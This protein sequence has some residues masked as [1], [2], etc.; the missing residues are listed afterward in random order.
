M[1]SPFDTTKRAI[2]RSLNSDKKRSSILVILLA[3]NLISIA[4]LVAPLF[5]SQP[6]YPPQLVYNAGLVRAPI[7]PPLSQDRSEAPAPVAA[8]VEPTEIPTPVEVAKPS[9]SGTAEQM[10]EVMPREVLLSQARQL[11]KN[12]S[13]DMA[14][15]INQEVGKADGRL[16]VGH[17]AYEMG[18]CFEFINDLDLA[19]SHYQL[20]SKSNDRDLRL[21]AQFGQ[22]RLLRNR[23]NISETK[24]LLA[25]LML[26]TQNKWGDKSG[27]GPELQYHWAELLALAEANPEGR[28]L[29]SRKYPAHPRLTL[30][31][32]VLLDLAAGAEEAAEANTSRGPDLIKAIGLQQGHPDLASVN[33]RFAQINVVDLIKKTSEAMGYQL[34]IPPILRADLKSRAVEVDVE[35][36]SVSNLLRLALQ[37]DAATWT[38]DSV[39]HQLRLQALNFGEDSD[40]SGNSQTGGA[41]TALRGALATTPNHAHAPNAFTILANLLFEAGKKEDAIAKYKDVLVRYRRHPAR[42]FASFNLAKCYL[43]LDQREE[44]R[45]HLHSV[46]DQR[47][48]RPIESA[49]YM[50]LGDLSLCADDSKSA[51]REFSRAVTYATD[52]RSEAVAAMSLAHAYV[53]SGNPRMALTALMNSRED[54]RQEPFENPTALLA[55]YAN[56]RAATKKSAVQRFGRAM[57]SAIAFVAPEDYF[58]ATGYMLMSDV[59]TELGMAGRVAET[60]KAAVEAH[61]PQPLRDQFMFELGQ[62][63]LVQRESTDFMNTMKELQQKGV[64]EWSHQAQLELANYLL[65]QGDADECMRI[66]RAV[67]KKSKT[68]QEKAAGLRMLGRAYEKQK[69][70]Y[71]AAI[72]FAGLL[73]AADKSKADET[74]DAASDEQ[75]SASLIQLNVAGG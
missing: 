69:D 71:N 21:A 48:G 43:T 65:R 70:H 40:V 66:C 24:H 15:Q 46:V 60:R 44:A 59:Y 1:R 73:P 41:E 4:I 17:L 39:T 28:D 72:C 38:Y 30:T 14:I 13:F 7:A 32:Q 58:G 64:N 55:A 47:S 26:Q 52:A 22:S 75:S 42:Q 68:Q 51:S 50:F 37:P 74:D 20:A 10:A 54:L 31:P 6:T 19:Q 62:Y 12:R 18:V 27:I 16:P 5:E 53:Q 3:T 63:H 35:G 45:Q 61:I 2:W 34:N 9:M 36:M 23:G 25:Q 49:G 29:L 67:I 11:L 57:T 8:T 56:F 33:A